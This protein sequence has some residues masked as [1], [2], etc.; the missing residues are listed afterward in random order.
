MSKIMTITNLEQVHAPIHFQKRKKI[1]AVWMR[2]GTSKGLF[3]HQKDLPASSKLWESIMLSAMGSS[4]AN[5]RQVNGVGGA[6]ST[7]SKV[8]IIA[9]SKRSN[10]DVDYTFIQVAPDQPRIDMTGNCG[11][12]ASGVGPFSL[13]E[14]IV[15]ARPGQSE[16]DIRVFNTNT[17]QIIVETVQVAPDGTSREDGEY[18]L[19]GVTG[20]ASPIKLAFVKPQGSMTGRMFPSGMKQQILNVDS[21]TQGTF[22]VRCSLVDAANPFVLVDASSLPFSRDSLQLKI[23]DSDL[24]SVVEEI[25]RAGAVQFGLAT[26]TNAAGL[27]RGTPKIAFLSETTGDLDQAD[28]EVLSFSM[29]KAHPSLQLTGA[30]CIAAAMATPGTVAW[31]LAGGKKLEMV[32]KHGMSVA[33]QDIASP[34]PVGIRHRSGIIHTET[35]LEMN[36]KGDVQVERVAV[37]RTA[38]RLFEGNVFY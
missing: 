10:I 30:V 35:M 14:G 28:I 1:P 32:P 25:R 17:E 19:A 23:D 33:N 20:T 13:D 6:T 16:I 5:S 9:K 8:A 22:S 24:L 4:Q 12:I 34:L 3:L 26:D 29:G 15:M 11:N 2:A 7:T 38:R 31:E 21:Q 36:H 37:L 27:I 18:E